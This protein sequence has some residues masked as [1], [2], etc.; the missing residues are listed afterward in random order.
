MLTWSTWPPGFQHICMPHT[1]TCCPKP[2]LSCSVN[3]FIDR[4]FLSSSYHLG[5]GAKC[6]QLG[7]VIYHS[8]YDFRT[9]SSSIHSFISRNTIGGTNTL[10]TRSNKQRQK[11]NKKGHFYNF[12]DQ[13]SH[14]IHACCYCLALA[15]SVL[16]LLGTPLFQRVLWRCL[17]S[18]DIFQ[19]TQH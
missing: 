19:S 5:G 1:Q 13:L 3:N 10:T 15:V 7:P 9:R 6:S 18:R 14:H 11:T 4:C 16:L 12:I 17:L 8:P 2:L